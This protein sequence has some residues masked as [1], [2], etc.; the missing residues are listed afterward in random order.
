MAKIQKKMLQIPF[1]TID[2]EPPSEVVTIDVRSNSSS[3]SIT[4]S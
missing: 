3:E 1:A 2:Y 4:S